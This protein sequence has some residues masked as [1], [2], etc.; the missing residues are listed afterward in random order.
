MKKLLVIEN[1]AGTLDIIGYIFEHSGFKVVES[2]K[3][4]SVTEIDQLSPN[5]VVI[6]YLLGDGFG[7]DLCLEIKSDP[8]TNHLPV[9]LYSASSKIAQ[10]AHDSHADAFIAKPFDLDYFVKMVN[11][12]AL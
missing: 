12:L 3:K 7:S 11:N 8:N 1:D 4:I 5:I 6:D 2:L 9:I 10:V